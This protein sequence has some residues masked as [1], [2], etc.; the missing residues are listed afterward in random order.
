MV[1]VLSDKESD[2]TNETSNED[3]GIEY[4]AAAVEKQKESDFLRDLEAEFNDGAGAE[5]VKPCA[6][7]TRRS[8]RKPST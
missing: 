5:E 3:T 6:K 4:G 7:R 1:K 2:E 8:K